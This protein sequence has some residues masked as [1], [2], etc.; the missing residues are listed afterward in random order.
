MQLC[1]SRPLF[2]ACR[3]TMHRLLIWASIKV[4]EPCGR[5]REINVSRAGRRTER[6]RAYHRGRASVR[7][8]VDPDG[9]I[10]R[11]LPRSG[12]GKQ[13]GMVEIGGGSTSLGYHFDVR[14]TGMHYKQMPGTKRPSPNGTT[15]TVPISQGMPS[16]RLRPNRLSSVLRCRL[17]P[18]SGA[19]RTGTRNWEKPRR[20]G[21]CW[22]YEPGG[23]G[24]FAW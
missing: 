12:D 23:G 10:K 9:R 6:L 16:Q 21:Y 4:R 17:G 22:W 11:W 19:A 18:K 7:Q 24:R 8:E 13:P 5:R 1:R 14:T 15:P 20:G 2:R 3:L